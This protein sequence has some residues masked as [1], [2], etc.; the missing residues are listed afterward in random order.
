MSKSITELI[1]DST[2]K[3]I[4]A[5]REVH[6]WTEYRGSMKLSNLLS[7]RKRDWSTHNRAHNTK[8][9]ASITYADGAFSLPGQNILKISIM[10]N[11]FRKISSI[12]NKSYSH[13]SNNL[14]KSSLILVP[15]LKKDYLLKI[16]QCINKKIKT[17]AEYKPR[18]I[19]SMEPI[20]SYVDQQ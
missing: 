10:S 17:R 1:L 18:D 2:V 19:E 9:R 4:N 12:K 8:A 15:F 11:A 5:A 13:T 6:L 16:L 3:P 7:N 20:L 14:I